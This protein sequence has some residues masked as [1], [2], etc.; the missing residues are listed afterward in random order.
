M[1]VLQSKKTDPYFTNDTQYDRI[2]R[3]NFSPKIRKNHRYSPLLAR[4]IKSGQTV[5]FF[6]HRDIRDVVVSLMEKGRIENFERWIKRR[7]LKKI[8]NDA[9]LYAQMDNVIRIGYS[10]L[11]NQKEK[12]IKKI[13]ILLNFNLTTEEIS[14]ILSNTEIEYTKGKLKTKE[15]S[16]EYDYEDHLHRNH[17]KDGKIG[18][19]KEIL[20]PGQV[21]VIEDQ[22]KEFL[23]Y[24]KY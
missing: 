5:A 17:I 10:E 22:A 14:Y 21:R 12:V 18:K 24:F 4:R 3:N 15:Y 9:L 19:W 7:R 23:D 2:L 11:M 13:M 20:S 1:T 16:Q 6:T 8:V